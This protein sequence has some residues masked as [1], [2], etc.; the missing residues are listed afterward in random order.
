MDSTARKTRP[1]SQ[2]R[3]WQE[4]TKADPCPICKHDTWCRVTADRGKVACRRESVGG[5][6]KQYKDGSEYWLH[7]LRDDGPSNNG[8]ARRK[9]ATKA[10]ATADADTLDRA[11]RLLLD[12]LELSAAHRDDLRRR[13]LTD[14][15]IDAGRYRTL[16]ADTSTIALAMLTGL[17]GTYDQ[18]P[19]CLSTRGRAAHI[20]ARP[21]LLIPVRDVQGRIVALKVRPYNQ[22]AGGKYQYVTSRSKKH[23]KAPSPGSPAHVPLGITGPCDVV[24]VTEGELKADVT[25][26]L[27]GI[28]TVSFPGVASWKRIL[29]IIK[30]LQAKTVRLAFDADA[31]TNHQVARALRQCYRHLNQAGYIVELER[32]P[33]ESGKGIDDLLVSGGAPEV[34]TGDDARDAVDAH[35]ADDGDE[36][37]IVVVGLDE[38]KVSAETMIALAK[39]GWDDDADHEA[40]IY[41]RVGQLVHVTETTDADDCG[42]L[43][44]PARMLRIRPLPAAI[45]RERI[46]QAVRLY[47]GDDKDGEPKYIRPPG[48]LVN[49][50]HQRGQYPRAIRP[51]AGI[52]RC[53]TLRPDGTVIQQAGYDDRTGLLFAPD[54]KYPP[55]PDA[56]TRDDA[57]RAAD[58]LLDV[59]VDFPFIGPA[60]RSVWLAM[61][62][63]MVG[64]SAIKGACP[65]FVMDGNCP[66]TG[67]SL[68]TDAAGVIAYG[69]RLPRK[70]WPGGDD[71]EV[72]KTITAVA[73][74]SLPSC[75]WDNVNDALGCSS[76]DAALT[77]TSWTDRLLGT[78]TTT[79]VLPLTTV[80]AA[81]GNNVILGGDTARRVL[82]CRLETDLDNPEERADFHHDNLV[83][84]VRAHRHHLAAAAVTVL[85]AYAHAGFPREKLTTWGSYEAWSE[86]IRNAIAWLGLPDPWE[87]RTIVR[88]ADRAVELLG[89]VHDGI[90]EADP[91]G[92]G[93][94]SGEIVKLLDNH[95]PKL[96]AAITELCGAKIDGRKIGSQLRQYV[97]RVRAGRRLVC[98]RRHGNVSRWS[99]RTVNR[100]GGGG[101]G[102]HGGHAGYPSRARENSNLGTKEGNYENRNG[103]ETC[104][105]CQPHQPL[106]ACPTC[107]SPLVNGHTSDGYVTV[108]CPQCD[109]VFQCEKEF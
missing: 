60:H 95:H 59:V 10:V 96:C 20:Q 35:R 71:N 52:V 19:G 2:N 22:Q 97:G 67:K 27:S 76:L 64:R 16:P 11:Y 73:L 23:P 29:P 65:M 87:T 46:A 55:I 88:Q 109:H 94:T 74:E 12:N 44:L 63:T 4:V 98:E 69:D 54:G 42:G 93:V 58:E 100:N 75:L 5:T 7:V 86:L 3:D 40:R 32:W 34:L 89:L 9:R 24:R 62:L 50:I 18:I 51:L 57:I 68:L 70:P 38:A 101:H 39:L 78:N 30:A 106:G 66:G 56:P 45:I 41:Q 14:A 31:A 92:S 102:G 81:T 43:E 91:D 108:E 33:L 90:T 8:H 107:S 105:P 61:V 83:G 104:P 13:G 80:W 82:Y 84:W 72:R 77:G 103:L 48:W 6:R 26:V 15:A 28:P 1:T 53:P 21:G 79:G 25:T 49:A 17:G 37:P 85:R 99:V 47:V 36:K